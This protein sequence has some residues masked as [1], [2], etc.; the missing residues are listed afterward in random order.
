M[1]IWQLFNVC[2]LNKKYH[3]VSFV[4][5]LKIEEEM[6]SWFVEICGW[7]LKVKKYLRFLSYFF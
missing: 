2:F 1:F 7:N 4:L 5:K 6:I 3:L